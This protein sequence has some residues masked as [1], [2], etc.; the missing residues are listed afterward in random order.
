MRR[1]IRLALLLVAT[2]TLPAAAACDD[3]AETLLLHG[4]VLTVD[5]SDS[6]AQAIAIQRNRIVAVGSDRE[7]ERYQCPGARI[8]D[9]EGRTVIPGLTDA[10]IHAI[11]GGQSY[12]FETHWDD[13]PTLASA[14]RILADEAAGRPSTQWL[15][16]GGGWHP[17]QYR[18]NS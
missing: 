9:L 4:N 7:L 16:V 1:K 15:I 14:L 3:M 8:V 5:R 18:L 13:I 17:D 2:F 11:R 10:H 6:T 12:R